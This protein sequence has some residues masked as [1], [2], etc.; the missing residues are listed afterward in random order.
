MT[1]ARKTVMISSTA[2]DLPEHR[3]EVMDACLRQG[4]FPV[5]M[6]NLPTNEDDVISAP[7]KMVD[8]AD[9]LAVFLGK[10]I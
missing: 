4:M 5:M 2:K 1:I 9:I 10:Q 3:K 7:L 8:R 6:E